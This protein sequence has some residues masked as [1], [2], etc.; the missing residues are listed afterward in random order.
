MK[1]I[2]KPVPMVEHLEQSQA[3]FWK[4]QGN[5]VKKNI[6]NNNQKATQNKAKVKQI[7]QNHQNG[8]S[9]SAGVQK[10]PN[11]KNSQSSKNTNLSSTTQNKQSEPVV[12]IKINETFQLTVPKDTTEAIQQVTQGEEKVVNIYPDGRTTLE[13]TVDKESNAAKLLTQLINKSEYDVRK[14]ESKVVTYTVSPGGGL[15][16]QNASLVM[17]GNV[18][19][20]GKVVRNPNMSQNLIGPNLNKVDQSLLKNET[21]QKSKNPEKSTP[22]KPS[23]QTPNSPVKPN[24][25]PTSSF[26]KFNSSIIKI[27]KAV[28]V[29]KSP[30]LA[31][32]TAVNPAQR[33]LLQ[34]MQ[35][36]SLNKSNVEAKMTLQPKVQSETPKVKNN[37]ASTKSVKKPKQ[38]KPKKSQSAKVAEAARTQQSNTM[39]IDGISKNENIVQDETPN[40]KKNTNQS[41][42]QTPTKITSKLASTPSPAPGRKG[43]KNPFAETETFTPPAPK[44]L[45]TTPERSRQTSGASTSS[46]DSLP[47]SVARLMSS[48]GC[49]LTMASYNLGKSRTRYQS[50]DSTSSEQSSSSKRDLSPS[51]RNQPNHGNHGNFNS[52]KTP[53][54]GDRVHIRIDSV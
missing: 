15:T 26:K 3:E 49:K 1:C 29:K 21:S 39:S 46:N 51:G 23:I 42:N 31:P 28:N 2:T 40:N 18:Q 36:T 20:T 7:V 50:G 19:K 41:N 9:N 35:N 33:N 11:S 8:I 24:Q 13:L 47:R 4:T 43:F 22:N 25:S 52:V 45:G 14:I 17:D 12:Q 30:N 6:R 32:Q 48:T 27:G 34:K 16:A 5:S 37:Q 38:L 10:T 53:P 44:T 54:M